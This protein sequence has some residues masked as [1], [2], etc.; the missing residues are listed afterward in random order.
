MNQ[1]PLD[2]NPTID[3]ALQFRFRWKDRP[4]QFDSPSKMRE[5]GHVNGQELA[6]SH[7]RFLRS[8]IV[9]ANRFEDLLSL[10]IEDEEHGFFNIVIQVHDNKATE[11]FRYLNIQLSKQKAKKKIEALAEEPGEIL[12]REILCPHCQATLVLEGSVSPQFYC[13]YCETIT[14]EIDL[15]DTKISEQEY[16]LCERCQM[17]S[18]PRKFTVFFFYFLVYFGGIHHK[19]IQCCPACFR[20]TAW[21]MLVGNLPFILGIPVAIVQLHRCYYGAIRKGPFRGLH[22][23]NAHLRKG[24]TDRALNA[25]EEI[26]ERHPLSAGVKYN[27]AVGLS[28]QGDTEHAVQMLELALDDCSNYLPAQERLV[29]I[30]LASGDDRRA[31]ETMQR[32]RM[33]ESLIDEIVMAQQLTDEE[34]DP[35]EI[36][37]REEPGE[38]SDT[39]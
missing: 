17:Y 34:Q 26:L 16:R 14:T 36:V 19:S 10:T 28:E 18:R 24:Q 6:L 29:E 12:V 9:D 32:F 23:A 25:Y 35:L 1:T 39:R 3:S 13:Q 15:D 31:F 33:D 27:V 37:D 2:S 22:E 21:M 7:A 5:S 30:Y 38:L 20:K 8:Q 4:A 11:L